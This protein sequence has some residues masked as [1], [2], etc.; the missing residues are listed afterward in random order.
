MLVMEWMI[1]II[2]CA[3]IIFYSYLSPVIPAF[4]GM[5]GMRLTFG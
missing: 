5:T 2:G 3:F 4:M 1:H